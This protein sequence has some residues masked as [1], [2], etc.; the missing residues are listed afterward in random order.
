L[1]A[2][3]ARLG[4]RRSPAVDRDLGQVAQL[5]CEVFDVSA[6]TAVDLGRVF[7]S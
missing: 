6:G 3:H 5:A 7:T 4:P 2:G 1:V